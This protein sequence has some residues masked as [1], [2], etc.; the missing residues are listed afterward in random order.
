[1]QL[2]DAPSTLNADSSLVPA[3]GASVFGFEAAG[4]LA[5]ALADF[6]GATEDEMRRAGTQKCACPLRRPWKTPT[7]ASVDQR[8]MKVNGLFTCAFRFGPGS[9][10]RLLYLFHSIIPVH[11]MTHSTNIEFLWRTSV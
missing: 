6:A 2:L 4:A 5:S 8:V 3:T 9:R 11:Y 10:R 7:A 1:M